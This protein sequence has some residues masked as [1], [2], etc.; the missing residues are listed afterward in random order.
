MIFEG[1]NHNFVLVVNGPDFVPNPPLQ[2][3][4]DAKHGFKNYIYDQTG[5]NCHLKA[6]PPEVPIPRQDSKRED[7]I[8]VQDSA[9]E[10][11]ITRQDPPPEAPIPKE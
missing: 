6:P 3:R 10:V 2:V 7:S 9:P 11:T 1:Y 4:K 5:L 8:P